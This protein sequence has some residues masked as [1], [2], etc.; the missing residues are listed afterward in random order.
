M[1]VIPDT[2]TH[3]EAYWDM[4]N[5]S[6][7]IS[8]IQGISPIQEAAAEASARAISTPAK[9][10]ARSDSAAPT[11]VADKIMTWLHKNSD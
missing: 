1:M 8:L 11:T 3:T 6:H 7:G 10:F 2:K 5:K 9:N 4:A